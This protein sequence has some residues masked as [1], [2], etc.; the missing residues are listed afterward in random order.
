MVRRTD[1]L[2]WAA[3]RLI[4]HSFIAQ[5]LGKSAAGLGIAEACVPDQQNTCVGQLCINQLPGVLSCLQWVGL[6]WCVVGVKHRQVTVWRRLHGLCHLWSL[7]NQQQ[8]HFQHV[9]S[10]KTQTGPF[11]VVQGHFL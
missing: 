3:V 1:L 6:S 11:L 10:V 5:T 9:Q 8:E 4:S 2:A 7:H